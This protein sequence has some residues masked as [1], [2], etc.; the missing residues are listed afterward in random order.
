MSFH[1]SGKDGQPS[2][3]WGGN[4]SEDMYVYNPANFSVNYANSAGSANSLNGGNSYSMQSLEL[5]FSTPFIDFH[6][7]NS[8]ADYTTRLIEDIEGRLSCYG[9]FKT[10]GQIRS[11]GSYDTTT[12]AAPNCHIANDDYDNS[13]YRSTSS[14]RRYK[15]DICN[16]DM[17][18]IRKLYNL[19]IRKYKYKLDYLSN[20][21]ERYNKDIYGF[22]AEELDEL[23]PIAVNHNQDG[24]AEM[25]NSNIIIPCLLGLIQDLNSRLD[26]IEKGENG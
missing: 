22:I 24:S 10:T 21:D 8:T 9:N 7:N 19:P 12:S 5:S 6:Y 2:W 1:W 13:I 11:K 20:F 25:W 17:S 23:M 14:S 18:E 26:K 4:D 15:F 3:L 16:A